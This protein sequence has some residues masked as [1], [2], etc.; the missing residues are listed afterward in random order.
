M[1]IEMGTFLIDAAIMMFAGGRAEYAVGCDITL[2]VNDHL[3]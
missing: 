3:A 2:N 1:R